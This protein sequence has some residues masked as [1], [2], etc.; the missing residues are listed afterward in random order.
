MALQPWRKGIVV[1]TE[2]VTHSTRSFFIQIPELEVFDFKPGQFITMD[3]PIDEKQSK[4]LRSYSIASAP[5]GSNTFELL[6]VHA[7]D[8]AGTSFLFNEVKAGH[9]LKLRGPVGVFTLPKTIERDI[10]FVCTG[11]GIAPFRSMIQHIFKNQLPHKN[12]CLIFGCRKKE[13][14][15]Y[16]D[17]LMALQGNLPGFTYIPTLSR[18]EWQGRRGYVHAIYEELTAGNPIADFYLCGWRNMV[19]EAQKRLKAIGYTDK[20][21]HIELYG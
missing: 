4:R 6:I 7:Q 14:L 2:Q 20:N 12:L 5:D 21:I 1:K 9:E 17:E 18:E 16:Y 15:L 11:T 19:D 3:L 13:D 8:G 10:Y